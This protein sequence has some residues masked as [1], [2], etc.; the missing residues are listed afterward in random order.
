MGPTPAPSSYMDKGRLRLKG[1]GIIPVDSSSVYDK[2]AFM[3]GWGRI[4]CIAYPSL[5]CIFY[6][7]IPPRPSHHILPGFFCPPT[8]SIV[9]YVRH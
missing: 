7:H 3:V 8:L 6:C 2:V 4:A 1:E 5:H 9:M